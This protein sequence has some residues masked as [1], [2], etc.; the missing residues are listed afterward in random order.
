MSE[1]D[2]PICQTDLKTD[3]Y[4]KVSEDAEV[5]DLVFRLKC[6]HAFHNGCLCR[7]LRT[8]PHCPVCRSSEG[9]NVDFDIL[10]D[11][12]GN[13]V[14]R[15]DEEAESS[16]LTEF[17][18]GVASMVNCFRHIDADKDVQAQRARAN[19]AHRKYRKC[20]IDISRAR[21]RLIDDALTKLRDTRRDVFDKESSKYRRVLRD[22][23]QAETLAA[24]RFVGGRSDISVD[25]S[26]E[27]Y[28]QIEE[29]TS[30]RSRANN[31]GTFGPMKSRFWTHG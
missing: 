10:V 29:S 11:E 17:V 21:K 18:G 15:M 12:T 5:N 31:D 14:M 25:E 24:Q 9:P 13:V 1:T 26:E 28:R 20:E 16:F 3:A 30:L 2:C 23:R 4:L 8:D 7:A 27:L 6:G 22:L 19:T